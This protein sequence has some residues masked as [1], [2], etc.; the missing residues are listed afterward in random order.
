MEHARWAWR[1]V[2]LGMA[3]A[4]ASC[5]KKANPPASEEAAPSADVSPAPSGEA[6]TSTAPNAAAAYLALAAAMEN[7]P[8]NEN[9]D[10]TD[11]AIA[12]H[13]GDLARVVEASRSPRCDFGV[14]YGQGLGTMMPHL[15]KVRG[16]A[17]ALRGDARLHLAAGHPDKA[18]QSVGA[19]LRLASHVA[20]PAR[21]SIEILVGVAVAD[22]G[23]Q[24]L[25]EHPELGKVPG[26]RETLDAIAGVRRDVIANARN[27]LPHERDVIVSSL[28]SES[29][30]QPLADLMPKWAKASKAEREAAAKT[31]DDL[32]GQ[33]IAAWD[34]PDAMSRLEALAA[35]ARSEGV[36]ELF[37]GADKIRAS[38]DRLRATCDKA[39]AVMK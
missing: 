13:A 36:G 20:R 34:A 32:F 30:M 4:L 19:I 39:E 28:R 3:T 14:D 31:L 11:E 22:L 33:A 12:L 18:A 29:G 8:R 17:R 9:G 24:F 15:G 23:A 26:K 25:V 27:V 37:V 6:P 5:E 21:T 2:V 38:V 7:A 35:R 1:G 10:W 16:V